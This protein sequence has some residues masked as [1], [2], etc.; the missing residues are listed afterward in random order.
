VELL[1]VMAV[2]GLL[3]AIGLP[4]L[5]GIGRGTGMSSSVR[6]LLD[7]LALARLTAINGRTRVCVVFLPPVLPPRTPAQF[8]QPYAA[9][10]RSYRTLLNAFDGQMSTY[11]IL[12]ER[13]VGD[14]P[15]QNRPRYVREWRRLPEGVVV[16][17]WS[18]D[19]MPPPA[20][21][22]LDDRYFP[23]TYRRDLP[24]PI[25]E[26]LFPARVREPLPCLIFEPTGQLAQTWPWEGAVTAP[27]YR[28][29]RDRVV[30]LVPGSVLV[31][32]DQNG[33]PTTVDLPPPQRKA[34]QAFEETRILVSGLTGR[35]SV[36]PTLL[37]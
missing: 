35:A 22:T 21:I 8:L 33:V 1:V 4:A 14:Q 36:E 28:R 20:N 26:P 30:T 34:G 11:T 31:G 16:A 9:D 17:P 18:F 15:G 19:E 10:K 27:Y 24:F 12:M 6:Q 29:S 5:R 7:D 32:R 23:F 3:A 13:S 37:R 2:I 25:T